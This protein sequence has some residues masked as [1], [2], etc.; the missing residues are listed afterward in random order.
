MNKPSSASSPARDDRADDA[1]A[2]DR[3][4]EDRAAIDA[5][6]PHGVDE[7][8]GDAVLGGGGPDTAPLNFDDDEIYSGRGK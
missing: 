1:E 8:T 4:V 6:G 3:D 2:T 5:I 7:P